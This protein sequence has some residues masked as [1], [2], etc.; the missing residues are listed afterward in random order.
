M[1]KD[2]VPVTPALP[3]PSAGGSWL[4]EADG[5]LTRVPEEGAPT[6]AAASGPEPQPVIPPAAIPP[7]GG[8][9]KGG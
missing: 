9:K 2:P 7:A 1:T 8:K 6:E 3:L 5:S 4:R